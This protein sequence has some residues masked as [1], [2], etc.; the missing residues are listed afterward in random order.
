MGLFSRKSDSPQDSF[1][2]PLPET[3]APSKPLVGDLPCSAKGCQN[4]T[5]AACSYVDRRNRHCKT[6]WCPEHQFL[7]NGQCYC[8]RH[9]NT[10]DAVGNQ[11]HTTYGF[12]MPDLANRSPSLVRWVANDISD[13]VEKL[14][15]RYRTPGEQYHRERVHAVRGVDGGVR[16]EATWQLFDHTGSRVRVSI[17]V[18]EATPTTLSARVG[19]LVVYSEVPPWILHR[20]HAEDV[21]PDT[22]VR[23]RDMFYEMMLKAIDEHLTDSDEP[24]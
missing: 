7:V 24:Y 5:G 18:R 17:E 15:E 16:W 1:S 22:D 6:A 11:E 20:E 10:V 14:L 2:A 23:E 3:R 12:A 9:A 21:D 4:S 13:R 8:R 19:Q